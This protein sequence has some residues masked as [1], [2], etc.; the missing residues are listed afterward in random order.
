MSIDA[1]LQAKM[2]E[3][4]HQ[5]SGNVLQDARAGRRER[6]AGIKRCVTSPGKTPCVSTP[7]APHQTCGDETAAI[8]AGM[9]RVAA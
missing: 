3:D 6:F 4:P 2:A 1:L 5:T 9:D 8:A 7:R